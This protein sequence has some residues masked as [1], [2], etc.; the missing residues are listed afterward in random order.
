MIFAVLNKSSKIVF[1]SSK[2]V[3]K[4]SKNCFRKFAVMI[5]CPKCKKQFKILESHEKCHG[6]I[7]LT[8]GEQYND[9]RDHAERCPVVKLNLFINNKNY[10]TQAIFCML[11]RT[12][13]FTQKKLKSWKGCLLCVDCMKNPM[14]IQEQK[15]LRNMLHCHLICTKQTQCAHC[16]KSV[17]QSEIGRSLSTL[18]DFEFDHVNSFN[19]S[20]SVG[21]MC[22]QGCDFSDII[23]EMK[24]CRVLC[25]SCHDAVTCVQTN[26]GLLRLKKQP[27]N[28]ETQLQLIQLTTTAVDELF[29]CASVQILLP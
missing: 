11:C 22:L 5:T 27:P 13:F 1:K 10:N 18:A 8:C 12:P 28:L 25:I 20:E 19:K 21:H 3:F 9:L 29:R 4:T 7:C 26:N 15:L 14:I 23:N 24:K 2:I 17:L 6:G 16:L